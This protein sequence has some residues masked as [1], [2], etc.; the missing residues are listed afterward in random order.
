VRDKRP[1]TFTKVVPGVLRCEKGTIGNFNY[2]EAREWL[3]A[4]LAKEGMMVVEERRLSPGAFAMRPSADRIFC[5]VD[6]YEAI[7]MIVEKQEKRTGREMP[8]SR[9]SDFN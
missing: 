5:G 2:R 7:M 3:A 9:L 6:V 1:L 8:R 4:Q